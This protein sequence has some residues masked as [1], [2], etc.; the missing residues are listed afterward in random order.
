MADELI[1]QNW[2]FKDYILPFLLVFVLVFAV[3]EKTKLF[4]DEKKQLNAIFAFVVGLIVIGVLY[5]KQVIGNMILFLTVS[6]VVVFVFLLLYGFV[7]GDKDEF[8]LGKGMKIALGIIVGIAV[9]LAVIWATGIN[10]DLIGLLFR[11]GWSDAFWTNLAF[12]VIF[13]LVVAW[14][15]KGVKKSE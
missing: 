6:L 4:G 15:L 9:V 14:V 5:P 2:I 11:Q 1:F 10:E 12:I 3:L 13:V 7:A 8:K